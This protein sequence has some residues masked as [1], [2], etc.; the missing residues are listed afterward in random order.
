VKPAGKDLS[1]RAVCLTVR[2]SKMGTSRRVKAEEIGEQSAERE[3]DRRAVEVDADTAEVT[4]SKE[5]L[6]APEARAIRSYDIE[7]KR[8]L[9]TLALPS[10]FREGTYLLPIPLIERAEELLTEAAAKRADLV[11]VLV[12][13][14]PDRCKE[15]A[16]RLRK[17]H[18]ASEYPTIDQVR[19]AY[20][21]DW[22]YIAFSV[23]GELK[24]ISGSMWRR[25]KE[26]AA[27]SM[28]EAQKEIQG[29]LRAAMAE[30]V[31]HL[32]ER[33]QPDA[34]TGKPKSFRDTAVSKLQE[35]LATFDFRN[36]ADDTDLAALVDRAKGLTAG[37]SPDALRSQ[38]TVRAKV[39][40]GFGQIKATLATMIIDK[41]QRKI[42]FED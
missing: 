27:K 5:L 40:A 1:E 24:S 34:E 4:V 32:V 25:E 23:P 41:P 36:L 22:Q 12:D 31:D 16:V 39:A 7:I 11:D 15:Q 21:F 14:Y 2:T 38:D 20:A 33:L 10:S 26:K 35:F 42:R 8:K 29:V 3:D 30:L 6:N 28:A 18:I 19:R 9:L 17:L 37:L 13:V